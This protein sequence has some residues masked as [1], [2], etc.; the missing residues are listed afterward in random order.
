MSTPRLRSESLIALAWA[1]ALLS[2]M[3]SRS[4]PPEGQATAVFA[5]VSDD[6]R[7]DK[8]ADGS[9]ATEYYAFGEGGHWTGATRDPSMDG[10][11]FIDVARAISGPLKDQN[12]LP[13][14][15]PKATK[16]LILVYWGRTRTP[17]SLED[18][19]SIQNLET[20]NA[21]LA[22]AKSAHD[23]N[24]EAESLRVTMNGSTMVCGHIQTVT[25][26]QAIVDKVSAD[27]TA[28]SA[29]AVVSAENNQRNQLDAENAAMLGFDTALN[30]TAGLAGT[31]F[32]HRRSEL[33]EEIEQ[34]RYFVVLMAYDFQLMW[35][36]KKHKLLWETRY[37]VPQ[38]GRGFDKYLLVMTQEASRYFGRR[39]R[40][41][42]HLDLPEGRV[43][44]G[45]VKSLGVVM[46][47]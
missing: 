22:T 14:R 23:Q 1:A 26:G 25:D 39:S 21:R 41:V 9:M 20:A 33:V 37:S 13:T 18:S 10:I 5:R 4:S 12:Y 2:P 28:T 43:D 11:A 6:Y 47:K 17:G 42:E 30:E 32:E 7:R 15:D 3:V 34:Q 19:D 35:K 27:N 8:Q 45:D 16:L 24:L 36:E 44:V 31:A 29:M 46:A 38:R 40:G